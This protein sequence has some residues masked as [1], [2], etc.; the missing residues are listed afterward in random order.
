M[1]CIMIFYLE[2]K[3]WFVYL[4]KCLSRKWAT[5]VG[6]SCVSALN[7]TSYNYVI[8]VSHQVAAHYKALVPG[9]FCVEYSW[10]YNAKVGCYKLITIKTLVIRQR[11][12]WVW[13]GVCPSYFFCISK[14]KNV[15]KLH[16]YFLFSENGYLS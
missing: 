13:G 3:C 11:F 9:P 12:R 1:A 14:I 2:C 6:E 15:I 8:S 5:G 7:C 16:F 4:L 10:E